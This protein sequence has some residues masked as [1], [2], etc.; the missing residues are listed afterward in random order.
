M[1]GTLIFDIAAS[2][3]TADSPHHMSWTIHVMIYSRT[4]RLTWAERRG[5]LV[6]SIDGGGSLRLGE[7]KSLINGV[8]PIFPLN[9]QN[10]FLFED[11]F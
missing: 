10:I 7:W 2:Y 4:D 11:V 9:A 8:T 1:R 3:Q 6:A 5:V